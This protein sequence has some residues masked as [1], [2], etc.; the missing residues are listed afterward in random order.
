M[1][2]DILVLLLV[3]AAAFLLRKPEGS[4]APR[5]AAQKGDALTETLKDELFALETDRLQGKITDKEYA[6]NKAALETV[7]KRAL[8]KS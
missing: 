3:A 1:I 7:I 5:T 2:Q 6:E 8:K 4:S